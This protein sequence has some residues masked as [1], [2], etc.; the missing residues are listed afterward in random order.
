MPELTANTLKQLIDFIIEIKASQETAEIL[1]QRHKIDRAEF[2]HERSSVRAN[3][4]SVPKVGRLQTHLPQAKDSDVAELASTL[5][6]RQLP[7]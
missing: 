7:H 3:I 2:E 1:L 6:S 5:A 4:F